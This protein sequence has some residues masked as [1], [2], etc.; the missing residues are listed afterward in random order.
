MTIPIKCVVRGLSYMTS[1][2]KEV[3]GVTKYPTFVDSR[4]NS[5]GIKGSAE[6]KASIAD[7]DPARSERIAQ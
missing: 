1:K 4:T 2:Q 7:F 6:K 5:Q 3:G